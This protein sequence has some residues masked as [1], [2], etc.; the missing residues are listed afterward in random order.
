MTD[1]LTRRHFL[2]NGLMV[3]CSAAAWPMLS[4]ATFAAAPFDH[5]LV[6]VILRGAMDGLDVIRPTGEPGLAALR[7]DL[8]LGDGQALDNFWQLH[9]GLSG[10]MPLWQAGELGFVKAVS[11]PYRDRR[12]HFDGQDLLEAGTGMNAPPGFAR[13]G[14]LNRL[15][16]TMPGARADTAFAVGREALPVLSGIAPVQSWAPDTDLRIGTQARRLLER[17]YED[18]PVFHAAASTALELTET[19][20]EAADAADSNAMMMADPDALIMPAAPVMASPPKAAAEITAF[21]RFAADRMREETR[22]VAL[23]LGGWDTHAGQAQAIGRPLLRLEQLILSLRAELGP[24]WDKTAFL[25][26]T[27][28]GRTVRQNGTGGT[29]H[30]TGGTMITAGGAIRGGKV[31]GRW[32]GLKEGDLYAGRDLMPTGDVRAV[33]AWVIHALAGT[34]IGVLERSIFPGL[35]MGSNPG[36]V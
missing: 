28:F 1:A 21:A 23:S 5:R 25:A 4:H 32:P 26:M 20:E 33:A 8:V 30:G 17:L 24:L 18:D 2:R 7:P 34:E 19:L 3:G 22:I 16:Q 9:P 31:L 29:D 35:D 14:W 6:V 27:E 12:S 36:I 11:T 13:D 10:L 15:L